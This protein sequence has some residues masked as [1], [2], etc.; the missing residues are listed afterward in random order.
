M[1]VGE[2]A[3]TPE[4]MKTQFVGCWGPG[5]HG[6]ASEARDHH[7]ASSEGGHGRTGEVDSPDRFGE[8]ETHGGVLGGAV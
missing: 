2:R 6:E 8:L 5:D 7:S 3:R 1:W 4:R